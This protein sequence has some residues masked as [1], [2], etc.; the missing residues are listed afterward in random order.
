MNI[1]LD[2]CRLVLITPDIEDVS[3]LSKTVEDALRGG[4]VA[5]VIIPQRDL[6][7]QKFQDVAMALVP[8]IQQAGAAAMIAGDTRIFGRCRADGFHVTGNAED[9][10]EAIQNF[11][12]EKIVGG[13]NAKDRDSALS[14]GYTQPDYLFFGKIDGDIK[15]EAHPKNLKLG[16]W[17]AEF[18]ETPCIVMAGSHADSALSVAEIGCDFVALGKAVF[19]NP[20]KAALKISEIN[21]VLD[22]K[23]PRFTD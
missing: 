1:K 15:P 11:A 17:W 2:R 14:I 16:Q 9:V 21:A 6:E 19:D 10:L 18:V 22:E 4:D 20:E 23:A 7:E 5:S 8:I 13:G 12:P 3:L